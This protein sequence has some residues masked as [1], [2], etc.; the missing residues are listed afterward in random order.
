MNEAFW[1]VED[2]I[3]YCER[4]AISARGSLHWPARCTGTT[5]VGRR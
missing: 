3:R 4:E 5:T 2:A 1:E